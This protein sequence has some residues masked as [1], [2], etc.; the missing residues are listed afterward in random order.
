LK[1]RDLQPQP[2]HRVSFNG[3]EEPPAPAS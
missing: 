3:G 1:A 2:R